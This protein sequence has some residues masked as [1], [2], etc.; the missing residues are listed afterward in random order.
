MA[1]FDSQQSLER[2]SSPSVWESLTGRSVTGVITVHTFWETLRQPVALVV[3]A[4]AGA[5]L[6]VLFRTPFFVHEDDVKMY[7]DL[8]MTIILAAVLI[9][10]VFAASKVVHE[11]LE[12][13]TML[14]LMSKPLSRRQVIVGKFLGIVLAAA[15]CVFVLGLLL[16]VTTYVRTWLDDPLT[17]K[18]IG[19]PEAIAQLRRRAWEHVGSVLPGLVLVWLQIATLVSLAVALSTRFSMAV[20]LTLCVVLFFAGHLSFDLNRVLADAPWPLMLLGKAVVLVLPYLENFNI[21][22]LLAYRPVS[23]FGQTVQAEGGAVAYSDVWLYILPV[24]LYAVVYCTAA[25]LVA[26]WLFRKR[27]LA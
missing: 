12:N 15:A 16:V 21:T 19:G 23:F 24:A 17:A 7:K 27:E 20:T 4:L 8:G 1:R 22:E 5:M 9:V 2:L 3:L 25:L 6:L 26:M 14:L 11:E 18:G 10:C 13:K